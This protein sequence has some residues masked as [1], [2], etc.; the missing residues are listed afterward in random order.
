MYLAAVVIPSV[1]PSCIALDTVRKSCR[2]VSIVA[3][4]VI[5]IP[6]EAILLTRQYIDCALVQRLHLTISPDLS[7]YQYRLF[8]HLYVYL[9][10]TLLAYGINQCTS[11]AL[12]I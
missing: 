6:L 11:A 8:Y 1:I 2:L 12:L 4:I 5:T 3:L 9:T 10:H 7:L